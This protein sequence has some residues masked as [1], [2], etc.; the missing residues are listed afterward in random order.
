M[1][2]MREERRDENDEGS[3]E[4][5]LDSYC[6][7]ERERESKT[8]EV[9]YDSGKTWKIWEKFFHSGKTWKLREF[10]QIL[11]GLRENSGKFVCCSHL[12]IDQEIIIMESSVKL[13]LLKSLLYIKSLCYF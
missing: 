2:A 12:F 6:F 4:N 8:S 9:P 10:C 5:H 13:T 3:K 11:P 1:E 7:Q